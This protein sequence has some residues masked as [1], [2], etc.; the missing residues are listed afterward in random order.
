MTAS[1]GDVEVLTF[2]ELDPATAYAVWRL[3]QRVFV[4]E[5]RAAYPDL[6]GRDLE[7]STRHLLVKEAGELVAYLRLLEGR[8]HGVALEQADAPHQI[9]LLLLGFGQ[10]LEVH[11]HTEVVA[12]LGS[13]DV[14]AVLAL[15]DLVG[16][17]LDQL[18]V[19]F[20]AGRDEDAGLGFGRADVEGDVVEVG[21]DL[22]DCGRG[23]A[24]KRILVSGCALG[25]S[26]CCISF[27]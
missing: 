10:V 27:R 19:A 21:D 5:Q 16:A 12:L 23:G 25:R 17:V 20:Y 22:V 24:G 6:D 18:A 1:T 7:P 8:G 3:R 15:Q 11:L 26:V 9:V 14:R 13:D 2:A 4:V